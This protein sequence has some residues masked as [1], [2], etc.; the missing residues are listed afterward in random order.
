MTLGTLQKWVTF[1]MAM[2][3]SER[4]YSYPFMSGVTDDYE[5]FREEEFPIKNKNTSY[6]F[7]SIH[8]VNDFF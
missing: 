1:D 8:L 7:K 4:Y 6:W 5:K 3:F 2:L